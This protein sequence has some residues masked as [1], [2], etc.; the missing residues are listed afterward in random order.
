[1]RNLLIGIILGFGL[2]YG[3]LQYQH[4]QEQLRSQ[5]AAAAIIGG[6][7]RISPW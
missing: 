4:H 6:P 3:V 7:N 5:Q 2:S 1:M